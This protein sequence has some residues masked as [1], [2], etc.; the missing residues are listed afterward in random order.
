MI[1]KIEDG[2]II[3]DLSGSKVI[4]SPPIRTQDYMLVRN[5]DAPHLATPIR[6]EVI[7]IDYILSPSSQWVARVNWVKHW[8]RNGLRH[9]NIVVRY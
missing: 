3:L 5:P 6:Y 7:K 1:V 9:T 4:G 2:G 8:T